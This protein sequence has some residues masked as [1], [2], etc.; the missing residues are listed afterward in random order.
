[1]TDTASQ[2]RSQQAGLTFLRI[3]AAVALLVGA[4][5]VLRPFLVGLIWAAILAY[6]TWPLFSWIRDRTGR[7]RLVSGLL[8]LFVLLG[9]GIPISTA[10][11]ALADQAADLLRFLQ[12]W[13]KEGAPLPQWLRENS[14]LGPRLEEARESL[15]TTQEISRYLVRSS[16]QLSER[17]V[18]VARNA[19][20]NVFT[21]VITLLALYSF[22]VD[23]ESLIAHAR[24]LA[25][26]VFPHLPAQFLSDVGGVVRAVVFG[27][28]GTAIVQGILAGIG[29][30]IF[31]VPSPVALGALTAVS[32]F[33]PAGPPL[34]WGGA[35]I[36]LFFQ[37]QLLAAVGMAVWGALLVSSVDNVLRPLLISRGGSTIP[38]PFLVVFFGV[39][40]GVAAFGLLGLFL[41]P[42]LLAVTFTLI[43]DYP[44]REP[45]DGDEQGP[46]GALEETTIPPEA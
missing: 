24:R 33:I 31:G 39:L 21:F 12:D 27:L 41:G 42:V 15:P 9:V 2:L 45:E 36:W 11:I 30:A 3:G 32:S 40:G 7:P 20:T 10:G 26:T 17:V 38:I 35:A 46:A 19:A 37:D 25:R 23:G 13:L 4:Y 44:E 28:L 29:L 16:G 22:Y 8:T 6:V 5:L 14:W 1:M 43:A 18:G 34:I